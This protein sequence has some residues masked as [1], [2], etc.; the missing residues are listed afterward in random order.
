MKC[1]KLA[2]PSS[3][4]VPSSH[5][6]DW[7][8]RDDRQ[9]AHHS[10]KGAS[11]EGTSLD[12]LDFLVRTHIDSETLDH[13]RL[14]ASGWDVPVHSVL[15]SLG[16]IPVADYVNRL[17]AIL[18]VQS[19]FRSG[20][21]PADNV[22]QIDATAVVP[23]EV[24]R[25]V[26][27]QTRKGHVVELMSLLRPQFVRDT[28]RQ[29]RVRAAASKLYRAAPLYSAA[30]KFPLWLMSAM[31]GLTGLFLGAAIIDPPLAYFMIA[32]IAA[33]PFAFIVCQ[34]LVVLVAYAKKPLPC[35]VQKLLPISMADLPVY[36]VL[37]PLYDEADIFPD[38]IDAL[39]R[40][41][42][43]A[44]KLDVILILEDI[45]LATRKA[46]EAAELP[47]F[48]RIVTVPDLAPR[49]KPKALN[50]ALTFAR[51]A[52]ITVFDAEDIPDPGQLRQALSV[53]ANYP[54][55]DCLQARL[56]IYNR[57]ENW[58][59]QQFALEYTALFDGLLPALERL[60]VPFPLG[61]TSNHF[62]R[63]ALEGASA[64]DAYNVTEDADLGIRMQ[65]MR[66][67]TGTLAST[68]WEEAPA[69]L[70]NWLPQRTRW[71]KGWM[72]TYMVHM[73]Q[74]FKL[75][76]ELGTWQFLGFQCLT[77]GFL[78][79]ALLHPFLYVI[80]AIE[81]ASPA[82]FIS[83]SS[84]AERIL[85]Y[86]ASFNLFAG[87]LASALLAVLATW[88][89]GWDIPALLVVSMPTYWLLS[90]LAAYR[91]LWQLFTAPFHWEKTR[92]KARV[93]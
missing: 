43:P 28:C 22:V 36:S 27:W 3:R 12:S 11:C 65:R 78:L 14:I 45:D 39:I 24:A 56:N 1:F 80:V 38:L 74:P 58:L 86:V 76:R 81:L 84:L 47:G 59:T 29:Q 19:A 66:Y 75:W 83:G 67:K 40:L 70:V 18:G 13:A 54:E 91:A 20:E 23:S 72:Q 17:A 16:W 35:L 10:Q 85:W 68:T 57:N 5:Q 92:H 4:Q 50:Y 9:R 71:L 93:C 52:F 21:A 2:V 89:R 49:T 48:I 44:A 82:P 34:R 77:L 7:Q 46:A 37:I 33:I 8:T 55:V 64:W 31:V 73:R 42:Y 60:G 63:S 61:G 41:D 79:S 69:T 53:F 26:T 87:F 25:I 15:L 62:R 6:A 90:S 51:G 32:F 30:G 88:R